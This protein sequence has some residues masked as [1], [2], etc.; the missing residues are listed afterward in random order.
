MGYA[1]NRYSTNKQITM[2]ATGA[3]N[4]SRAAAVEVSR[5][6]FMH[7]ATVTDAN[8]FFVAGG[9]Q[10]NVSILL[11][12]S[13]EGTGTFAAIGTFALGSHATLA[14]LDGAVTSTDF[15]TGDDIVANV[16]LGSATTVPNVQPNINYKE[17]FVSE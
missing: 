4:G 12:K 10:A 13:F 11:G 2:P 15:A 6:T 9:S 3:L 7:N 14:V 17:H 5:M 8:M 1:E 16:S